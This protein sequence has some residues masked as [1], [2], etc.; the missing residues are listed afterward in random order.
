MRCPLLYKRKYYLLVLLVSLVGF[1]SGSPAPSPGLPA[2]LQEQLDKYR[3]KD[4]LT[5]WIYRQIQ[6]VA[7]APD[8]RAAWLDQVTERVWRSPHSNEE[9]QAWQ[10]LLSNKGWAFLL[11]GDIVH[12]TDVYTAAYDWAWD[13]RDIADESLVLDNILKPLGNNYTRLGDYEQA[14]F[15][16]RKALVI[17]S[18]LG[19]KAALAGTYSNLANTCSNMG[20]PGQSLDYCRQGLAVVNAHSALCGLLLSEQADAFGQ[21]QQFAAAGESIRKSIAVLEEAYDH[22]TD[23]AAGYWLLMAYQQAGDL[24]AGTVASYSSAFRRYREALALQDKLLQQHGAI[25]ARERAKL[26]WRMGSLCARAGETARAVY[27]LDQCLA[28]L[29]PGKRI[30]LVDRS[31]LFA[32]NTLMDLLFTRAGLYSQAKDRDNALRLYSLCFATEKKLRRE[33]ISGSSRERSVSDSRLRYETA[34]NTAWEAWQDTH[35]PLYRQY[36]LAFMESSK[37]QLLLEELRQSYPAGDSLGNRIRLLERAQSYYRKEALGRGDSLAAVYTTQEKQTAWDIAQLRKKMGKTTPAPAG[38]GEE[39]P[40]DSSFT[41]LQPRQVV[42]SF[43]A[44]SKALYILEGDKEGIRF[45]DRR[46]MPDE[47]QDTVRIFLRTWFEKGAG[48]MI[49]HPTDYY[50]QAWSLYQQLFGEHPLQ[51]G[52]EYILL[53]DGAL[54]LLPVDALVTTA[55]PPPSPENW[56]FLVKQNFISYGWSLQTLREQM[57][58]S[59]QGQVFSGF[60]LSG[61]EGSTPLLRAVE[62]EKAG[63]Q[64]ILKKGNWYTDQQAT[65]AAFR[66]ALETSS[67]VHISSHAF[68]KKDTFD[69]PHIELFREPFY[70]FELKGLEHHP[71]LVVL[72]ACR[73]GDGRMVTGEGVQSLARAFS[74]GGTNAVVAGWWN[75]NDEATAQLMQRFYAML[76]GGADSRTDAAKALHYAK[77]MWL[78]DPAIPYLHKLP[79]YWAA[80]NYQG[81]P[82]PLPQGLL[83]SGDGGGIDWT[84]WKWPLWLSLIALAWLLRSWRRK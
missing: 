26:F 29:I 15:I 27:W 24:D 55:T 65:P 77:L 17:A 72:S 45:L 20:L 63:L 69:A 62:S 70:L 75:V 74:A 66:Q 54:D 51:A 37:A 68:T 23:P 52:K 48:A 18:G 84:K 61:N 5:Q 19:D 22:H 46:R 80:L 21:L 30:D 35:Q 36:I 8:H 40:T 59:G 32:E 28:V 71:A 7:E 47:W 79:Y 49:N 83:S 31:D 3:A 2:S 1:A 9:I 53:P 34:M 58:S 57:G 42:R 14:L 33:L 4:D 76:A 16:H 11:S 60:F 43:F 78:Q 67:V 56:P 25:R 44:G 13:H 12:S 6:W 50:R 64:Q 10:D 41:F 39:T 38:A 81:N 82:R 73:T